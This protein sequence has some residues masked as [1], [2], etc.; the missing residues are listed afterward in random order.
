MCE[1]KQ[2]STRGGRDLLRAGLVAPLDRNRD[3]E[4]VQAA[5]LLLVAAH[6]LQP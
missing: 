3:E 5:E 4:A 6:L 1:V 2:G